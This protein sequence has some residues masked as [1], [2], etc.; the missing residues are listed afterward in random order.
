MKVRC[1]F[2]TGEALRPYESKRLA[3][4]KLGRFGSTGN[5]EYGEITV[6]DEYIVM[7]MI[8]FETYIGYLIDDHSSISVCPCHLF[9]I[10]DDK[11]VDKWHFR[12]IEKEEDIYPFIQGI[13]GYYELC[14]DKKSYE[15]LIIEKDND[16]MLIY[17]KRKIEI[18][19][20]IEETKL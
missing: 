3:K 10:I 2:N 16:S 1:V 4:E 6:G 11:I 13:W 18:E 14:A 12:L 20:C 9:E 19:K 8:A 17:F 15:K 5:T 7:G